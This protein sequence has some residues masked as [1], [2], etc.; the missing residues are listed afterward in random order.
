MLNH[1]DYSIFH[2]ICNYYVLMKT[3]YVCLLCVVVGCVIHLLFEA[4][5][6]AFIRTLA[7][8]AKLREEREQ[9]ETRGDLMSF[10][11]AF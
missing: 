9:R 8:N 4:P 7:M 10:A 2:P 1:V 11:I 6:I 5:S 3:L